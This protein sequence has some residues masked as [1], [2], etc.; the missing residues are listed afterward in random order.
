MAACKS[1]KH[2]LR[3]RNRERLD[4]LGI[5]EKTAEFGEWIFAHGSA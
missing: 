1:R 3:E 5:R 2:H 4:V